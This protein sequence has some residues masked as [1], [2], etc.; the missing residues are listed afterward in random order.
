MTA[1]A[2]RLPS[3]W[4]LAL[5]FYATGNLL[6]AAC[7]G[8][9]WL[10][11]SD[12][13]LLG[14]RDTLLRYAAAAFAVCLPINAAALAYVSRRLRRLDDALDRGLT[15]GELDRRDVL[16]ALTLYRFFG[17]ITFAQWA[18]PALGLPLWL[19][20]SGF[21]LEG[22]TALVVVATLGF[23]AMC[24]LVVYYLFYLVVRSSIAPVLLADGSLA[25]LGEVPLMRAWKH[26]GLLVLALGVVQ[27]VTARA[28]LALG[29]DDLLVLGYL[30]AMLLVVSV[31]QVRGVLYAISRPS[32]ELASRMAA[33]REGNLDVKAPVS[34]LDTFG[35]L[36]SDFNAMLE[37]LKQRDFLRE[38]FG[39]YV[40][41]QVAEEIL[42]GR[43]ALG[44][45]RRT[46]TVLFSDIRGFTR[47]SEQMAPEEVVAFLNGYLDMMVS[48]VFEHG[49]VLDKFIG[50]AVMAVF[51]APVSKGS[52]DD[53]ARA[54]VAC[55]LEM[56]RRLDQMNVERVA[57]GEAPIE[58]GIGVN[59]G[60]LVA[61]NI[62]SPLRM[63]YTVIGDTVNL[64]SRLEGLTKELGRRILV[65]ES[66][67]ALVGDAFS[68]E[69]LDRVPVRGREQSVRVYS[70]APLPA[71][72]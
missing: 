48:C 65:S 1:H 55:A 23:G 12:A 20:A 43:V 40:T 14:L 26:I 53:D 22:K 71:A 51:G 69:P 54:A 58:I 18:V 61:G 67:A 27:P 35:Q 52:P 2:R 29:A 25:P 33:V 31:L 6:L 5:P 32:G 13:S 44:G 41:R 56:S 62:G 15:L 39:R 7:C 28:L 46:A 16:A 19:R 9:V 38:T 57:R 47:M 63:E 60:E 70:L 3:T 72:S 30:G 50:D 42:A 36:A 34:Q 59:S 10:T 45:E 49:G 24:A 66:T 8:Y 17:A 11:L 68:L 37:G 21:P 4:S 64:S